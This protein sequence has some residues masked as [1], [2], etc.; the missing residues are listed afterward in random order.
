MLV[1]KSYQVHSCLWQY[2]FYKLFGCEVR[3][4]WGQLLLDRLEKKKKRHYFYIDSGIKIRPL[5]K[6]LILRTE[7]WNEYFKDFLQQ[8]QIAFY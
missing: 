1:L 8:K 6:K 7:N 4:L 3:H 5:R 2:S